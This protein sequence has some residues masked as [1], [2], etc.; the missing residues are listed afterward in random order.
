[1]LLLIVVGAAGA[2]GVAWKLYQ[3][4]AQLARVEVERILRQKFPDWELT[5]DTLAIDPAGTARLTDVLLRARGH[6]DD[7]LQV[8]EIVVSIDRRLFAE[9]QIIHVERL[10]L[11]EPTV[12]LTR[13]EAGR[14]NW[15]ELP[16][17]PHSDEACPEIE[18]L[19]GTLVVHS[20]R[21]PQL[22]ETQFSCRSVHGL[23]TPSG[24]RRYSI[25]A[26]T[27]VDYAG[28][29]AVSGSVDLKSKAWSLAGDIAAL[30]TEQGLLG[31]AAGLSP[32]LRDRMNALSETEGTDRFASGPAEVPVQNVYADPFAEAEPAAG[33][34]EVPDAA[35][36]ALPELGVQ[37]QLDVHF[38]VGK[39]ADNPEL[40]YLVAATIHNGQIV[41]EPMTTPIKNL[42]GL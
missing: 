31:V 18:I 8:P 41:N 28:K 15:Q 38:E 22:P 5:F 21:S 29:L 2:G 13:S 20:A 33:V 39:A 32:D 25:H 3:E 14:W 36:F 17:P 16:P 35:Q 27:E 30:N 7:L 40:Q 12:W 11:R 1:M 10:L 42:Q 24:H 19:G 34:Q 4:S 23:L 37:A 26:Q 9:H 6:D